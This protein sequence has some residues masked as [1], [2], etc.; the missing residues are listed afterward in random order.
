MGCW[1]CVAVAEHNSRVVAVVAAVVVA[2]SGSVVHGIVAG[3]VA[4]AFAVGTEI[5][6]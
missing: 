1:Y 4:S 3:T 2:L 5:E 6:E